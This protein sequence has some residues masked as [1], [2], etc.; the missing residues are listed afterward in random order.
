MTLPIPSSL[1]KSLYLGT[2][3]LHHLRWTW[4][5][6]RIQVH[7]AAVRGPERQVSLRHVCHILDRV[8]QLQKICWDADSERY[9]DQFSNYPFW[10]P[11]F[12]YAEDLGISASNCLKAGAPFSESILIGEQL[13]IRCEI[14]SFLPYQYRP[15]GTEIIQA[16]ITMPRTEQRIVMA[17]DIAHQKALASHDLRLLGLEE[18]VI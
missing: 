12:S 8:Y 2:I 6:A 14:D 16:T 3:T 4:M 5:V 1:P 13:T 15:P 17:K 18:F 9:G 7:Y 10:P 11:E